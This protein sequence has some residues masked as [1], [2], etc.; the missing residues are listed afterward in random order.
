MSKQREKVRV[1]MIRKD[2]VYPISRLAKAGDRV[3]A[4]GRGCQFRELRRALA[5]RALPLVQI[6]CGLYVVPAT[7]L[8]HLTQI[9]Q[10]AY[11]L[12]ARGDAAAG[13]GLSDLLEEHGLGDA[14]DDIRRSCRD[15][16]RRRR[17]PGGRLGDSG[18][19]AAHLARRAVRGEEKQLVKLSKLQ[20]ELLVHAELHEGLPGGAPLQHFRRAQGPRGRSASAAL[21]RSIHR[22]EE[23]GLVRVVRSAG[24]RATH[25]FLAQTGNG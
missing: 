5:D 3:S 25:I 20:K 11:A 10:T 23:R 9:E 13:C 8:P 6:G 18:T 21:S 7:T 1:W 24:R 19:E 4:D 16:P 2:G 15:L 17:L 12:E 14:M 22:L